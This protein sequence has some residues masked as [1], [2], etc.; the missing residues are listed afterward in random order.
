MNKLR[1][2][3]QIWLCFALPFLL[4][5]LCFASVLCRDQVQLV[6]G[7]S[8]YGSVCWSVCCVV[9]LVSETITMIENG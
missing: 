3:A 6:R 4:L 1:S 8:E 2:E 7:G 9:W 5:C